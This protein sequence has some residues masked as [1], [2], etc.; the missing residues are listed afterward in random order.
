MHDGLISDPPGPLPSSL[1]AGRLLFLC[2]GRTVI[3]NGTDPEGPLTKLIAYLNLDPTPTA[4]CSV[5][6]RLDASKRVGFLGLAKQLGRLSACPDVQINRSTDQQM[7]SNEHHALHKTLTLDLA[8]GGG[9]V[10]RHKGASS[11]P[12]HLERRCSD[13]VAERWRIGAT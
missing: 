3:S 10:S 13:L 12:G 7:S 4:W 5:A 6:S 2:G 1:V 11:A 9:C 8:V